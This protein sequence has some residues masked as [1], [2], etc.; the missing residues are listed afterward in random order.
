MV[1]LRLISDIHYDLGLNGNPNKSANHTPFGSY[2]GKSLQEKDCITLIAGD[3]AAS[4][5]Q[6]NKFFH[7]FFENQE[8]I[9]IEGNH[10]VYEDRFKTIYEI[11]DSYRN[12]FPKDSGLWHYLENDWMWISNSNQSIAIIGSEFYTDYKYSL[13]KTLSEK[14][15]I[16]HNEIVAL[17]GIND[18]RYGLETPILPITPQLYREL[19]LL[20]QEEIT[21]CYNEIISINPEAKIIL[22]THHCLSPKCIDDA[23][24]GDIMNASYVSDLEGWINSFTNIKL[25]FSGHV[26]CGKDFIFGNNKR[27][28]IN[29]CGYILGRDPFRK[30]RKFNPN[31]ILDF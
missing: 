28:I 11:K 26:H 27:Y 3:I 20:A 30:V 19:N 2:F 29:A 8:V 22:M 16:N 9:F 13:D 10:S 18:F 21:R 7:D 4:L 12:K 15:I 23:Y 31:L 24:I 25:V 6:T 5:K 1:R 14:E 17:Y